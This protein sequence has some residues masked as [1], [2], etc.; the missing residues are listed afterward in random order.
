MVKYIGVLYINKERKDFMRKLIYIFIFIFILSLPL[1][2]Q[3]LLDLTGELKFIQ[4]GSGGYYAL[5]V[6]DRTYALVNLPKTAG[7]LKDGKY[8]ICGIPTI[9]I[10][11]N[12]SVSGPIPLQVTKIEAMGNT[13]QSQNNQ[14]GK[15]ELTGMIF[16]YTKDNIQ[17]YV[18]AVRRSDNKSDFYS[19]VNIPNQP[20]QI[21]QGMYKVSGLIASQNPSGFG[22]PL[23]ITSINPADNQTPQNTTVTQNQNEEKEFMGQVVF[24]AMNQA[25]G[26]CYILQTQDRQQ[27]ALIN[28]P[29]ENG[30]FQPGQYKVRGIISPDAVNPYNLGTPM[31]VTDIKL[32]AAI[33]PN[34]PLL[35]N[36]NNQNQLF[37]N[38]DGEDGED[39]DP[40]FNSDSPGEDSD[41]GL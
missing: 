38:N 1:K 23:Q 6:E 10:S 34:N 35:N 9:P 29:Q 41:G 22:T 36:Q 39:G 13:G 24:I 15:V 8:H 31:K 33:S 2:A 11:D 3:N 5:I 21:K 40:L 20:N 17:T 25:S 7:Q 27:F 32:V 19:L 12:T 28:L 18:L 14:G 26:G 16:F 37:N 30:K 4:Q